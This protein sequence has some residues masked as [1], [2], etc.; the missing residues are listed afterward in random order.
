MH[1]ILVIDDEPDVRDG[2]KRV[3]DR[4]GFSVRTVDN[5][6]DAMLEL[7]RLAADVVITDIIMPKVNGVDAIECIVREFPMVRIVAI[8]GGGNFDVT[9]Y[10]PAAITTTAYLAAA[11]RAGAHCILTKPFESRE[12][13]EAVERVMGAA[14]A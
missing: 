12:L 8:S 4:A 7:R 3:L 5:A 13:I 10:Q 9:G 6:T 14:G 11:K 2:I 1:R